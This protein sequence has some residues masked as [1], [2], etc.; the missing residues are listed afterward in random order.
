M[1]TAAISLPLGSTTES[2]TFSEMD[3]FNNR[4]RQSIS[5]TSEPF[6]HLQTDVSCPSPQDLCSWLI[7]LA[8]YG[9]FINQLDD[10]ISRLPRVACRVIIYH[11]TE[12][13]GIS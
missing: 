5:L 2:P 12:P 10:G 3:H 6:L 7:Y 4:E 9:R 11:P 1:A 13:D 8:K